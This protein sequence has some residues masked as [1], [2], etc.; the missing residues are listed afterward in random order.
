MPAQSQ[1]LAR[2]RISGAGTGGGLHLDGKRFKNN[3]DLDAYLQNPT[4]QMEYIEELSPK[5][6]AAEEAMLR[7]RLLEEGLD[8]DELSKQIRRGKRETILL[9][10]WRRWCR[11]DLIKKEV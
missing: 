9:A 6:K 4:G 11:K 3:A 7:L 8:T 2:R 1:L 5:E 10:G